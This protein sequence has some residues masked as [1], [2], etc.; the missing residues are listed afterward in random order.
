MSHSTCESA[1][2]LSAKLLANHISVTLMLCWVHFAATHAFQ[3]APGMAQC[4]V[5]MTITF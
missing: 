2:M 3:T 4:A 5:F 1:I